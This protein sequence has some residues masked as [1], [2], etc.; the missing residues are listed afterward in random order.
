MC[1]RSGSFAAGVRWRGR[2]MPTAVR[3]GRAPRVC[4][5]SGRMHPPVVRVHAA[6][7]VG[8]RWLWQRCRRHSCSYGG[9]WWLA[10]KWSSCTP[11]GKERNKKRSAGAAQHAENM[12][13]PLQDLVQY[14]IDAMRAAGFT[15]TT[16]VYFASGIFGEQSPEGE[17]A[18]VEKL[19][20]F[21]GLLL[22]RAERCPGTKTCAAV[23]RA[24]LGGSWAVHCSDVS[25]APLWP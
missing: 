9:P 17:R 4:L 2:K 25:Q 5:C 7:C 6:A 15:N 1:L 10:H 16:H 19:K 13:S 21:C 11:G 24:G 20:G 23:G 22:R 8:A 3:P 12:L 18:R 14:Y